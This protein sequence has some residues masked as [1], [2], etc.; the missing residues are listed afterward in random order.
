VE[1][2]YFRRNQKKVIRA[3]VKILKKS[4]KSK[5]AQAVKRFVKY[6][7]LGALIP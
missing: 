7:A 3:V 2:E 6:T 1:R 5:P 4:T